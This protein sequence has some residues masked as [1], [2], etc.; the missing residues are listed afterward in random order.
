M[1]GQALENY[2]DLEC[3]SNFEFRDGENVFLVE[4]KVTLLKILTPLG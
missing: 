2:L 4:A 1:W 3:A